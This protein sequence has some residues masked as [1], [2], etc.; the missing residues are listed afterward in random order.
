MNEQLADYLRIEDD[1]QHFTKGKIRPW[2]WKL[3]NE[4]SAPYPLQALFLGD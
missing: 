2:L 4:V 3:V 1:K